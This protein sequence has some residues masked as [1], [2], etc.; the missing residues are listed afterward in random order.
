[1]SN[2]VPIQFILIVF[3]TFFIGVS[4]S[5]ISWFLLWL[6]DAEGY[7]YLVRGFLSG[8]ISLTI[9]LQVFFNIIII[10]KFGR[11]KSMIKTFSL[12]GKVCSHCGSDDTEFVDVDWYCRDCDEH[13]K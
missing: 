4:V 11:R 10:L 2:R 7:L 12:E 13:F 8:V 3:L 5:V 9:V 6:F 1:M